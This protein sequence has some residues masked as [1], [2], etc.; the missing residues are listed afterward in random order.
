MCTDEMSAEDLHQPDPQVLPDF[1][2][3]SSSA[4]SRST[5]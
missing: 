3:G 4:W 1:E 5:P 2:P